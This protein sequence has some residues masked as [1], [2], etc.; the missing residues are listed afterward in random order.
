MKKSFLIVIL[1]SLI[2]LFVE[3]GSPDSLI[4]LNNLSFKS[5][6]EKK[7]FFNFSQDASSDIVN[8][9]ITPFKDSTSN[10]ELAHQK[11]NECVSQL[12]GEIE[13]KSESKKIKFVY[14]F[15]H[16]RFFKV[17][18]LET[19]FND[20]FSKGEYN[21]V[22]ASALYAIIFS[23]L[24][25]P[26]QIKEA[27][28]HAYLVAYPNTLK[29]Y[30]E[31]TAPDKGYYQFKDELV[32]QFIKSL[33]R[34][35]MISKEE[36]DT[37][38]TTALFNKYFFASENISLAQLAGLQYY[39]YGLYHFEEKEFS[40]SAD[41]LKKACYLYPCK[42][43]K[44]IL[45]YALLS[46]LNS[47]QYNTTKEVME[48]AILCAYNN[49]SDKDEISN[50]LI[51]SEFIRIIQSQ[52]IGKADFATFDSSYAIISDAI[53]DTTLKKDIA[54]DYHY[55]L[56]RIGYQNMK[57]SVYELQHLQQA[58]AINPL[59]L[60]LRSIILSYMGRCIGKLND[61]GDLMKIID[62][63]SGRFP[64]LKEDEQ[65]ISVKSNCLLELSYQSFTLNNLQKGD[66]YLK[67]FETLKGNF[68]KSAVSGEFV[69]KAYLTAAGVYFKRSNYQKAKQYIKT[70]LTYSPESF[71][72]KQML[73]QF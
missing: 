69:E 41:A 72:L 9:L 2:A 40:S 37:S 48:L 17:Y 33:H 15:V 21:C 61:A 18:K 29:I 39:N 47:I 58:Y 5:E 10:V 57:D 50:H 71:Q 64:Y 53:A 31:S 1:I 32:Q 38:S 60:D 70:G 66:N 23:R 59:H 68:K 63:Y 43:I 24:N 27:P 8:I 35:K 7:A 20:I 12:Q 25:I 45:K 51:E 13:N 4:K 42:R 3:A 65:F 28:T 54:F 22:S 19:S 36:I 14:D 62:S 30:V 16:K 73:S 46:Y 44:F 52:L 11:I 6:Q 26:Y 56:A 67:E 49:S 55:E 34:D